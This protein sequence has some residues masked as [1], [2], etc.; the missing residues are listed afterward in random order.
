MACSGKISEKAL[1]GREPSCVVCCAITTWTASMS[2]TENTRRRNVTQHTNHPKQDLPATPTR[3]PIANRENDQKPS[4]R[5]PARQLIRLGILAIGLS[6]FLF[7]AWNVRCCFSHS[8]F[9]SLC[10]P[11]LREP[12]CSPGIS[13]QHPNNGNLNTDL[14]SVNLDL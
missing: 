5:S 9:R 7:G 14:N 11:Q 1:R 13:R 10:L 3:T 2:A 4:K 6:F 8:A 12:L